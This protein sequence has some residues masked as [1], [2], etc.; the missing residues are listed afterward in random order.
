MSAAQKIDSLSTDSTSAGADPAN[1]SVATRRVLDMM[2]R[3]GVPFFLKLL[4]EGAPTPE[5]IAELCDCD[6]DFIVQSNVFRGKTTKK[7]FLL[8]SSS[9]TKL[10]DKTIGIIVGENLQRADADFTLR[11]TGYPVGSIPPLCHLN[12]IPVMMDSALM[13]FPRVWCPAGAPNAIVSI[14]TLVLARAV[15]ARVVRLD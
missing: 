10:N 14:P 8:L 2:T 5:T 3:T 12:R 6:L 9:T 13:R 4:P 7:P 11:L 1:A 15:S